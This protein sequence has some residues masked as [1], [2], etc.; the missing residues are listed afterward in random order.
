MKVGRLRDLLR[1]GD[2]GF[3]LILEHGVLD[4]TGVLLGD[5]LDG[6]LLDDVGT[7]RGLVTFQVA[8]FPFKLRLQCCSL[9]G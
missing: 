4:E 5:G 3:D 8:S 6:G 9:R 1:G 7:R 2:K